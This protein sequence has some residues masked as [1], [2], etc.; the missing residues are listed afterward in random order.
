[1]LRNF[2]L[3]FSSLNNCSF[4][5]LTKKT[6][7]MSTAVSTD[8]V[9]PI[10]EQYLT[11]NC[12]QVDRN[13][14]IIGPVSKRECHM[15]PL[16]HRAFSVFIFDKER[17]MLLQK[18]SA[19]KITFPL[20][21][22]N[23]CC[24]FFPFSIYFYIFFSHPLFGIEQN[25][26][27][28]VKVAAKRKLLHELGIDTVNVGDMEVMGRFIYLARSD[29]IWVEHEL[30]YA[31]IVTNFDA[32]FKPNPEEVSEVRFVTPDELNEMFIGGKELFSPWFSLFY[33]FH[34]LKTWWEK[35]DDLKSVRE[36][37]DVIH[38]LN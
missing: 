2:I 29:S 5:H 19:T 21:W 26:V 7:L 13:D 33:K 1:M 32:A 28:G 23:S 37:D 11:E 17:R 36:S 34:W 38:S 4:L 6:F 3:K 24:R 25:G 22:T 35:L 9:D 10:Q 15:N 18:R 12:I 14:G 16:L 27:D 20:V 30:D 8:S 31:I